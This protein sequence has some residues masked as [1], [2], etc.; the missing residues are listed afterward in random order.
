[1]VPRMDNQR[2]V[3]AP[4][5]FLRNVV[6]AAGADIEAHMPVQAEFMDAQG[7]YDASQRANDAVFGPVRQAAQRLPG[8][9]AM[10]P[11]RGWPYR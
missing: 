10:S 4:H 9:D 11:I 2:T 6:A 5:P 1:M 3:L 8:F 7:A